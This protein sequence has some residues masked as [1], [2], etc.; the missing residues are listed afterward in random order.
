MEAGVKSYMWEVTGC[1]FSVLTWHRLMLKYMSA[2]TLP[3]PASTRPSLSIHDSPVTPHVWHLHIRRPSSIPLL[4]ALQLNT[5]AHPLCT[6]PSR[7]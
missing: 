2:A 4:D 1:H 7:P 3:P 6:S 5:P